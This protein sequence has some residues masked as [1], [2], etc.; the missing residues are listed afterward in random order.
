MKSSQNLWQKMK[1]I[2]TLVK[3]PSIMLG[4]YNDNQKI[5]FHLHTHEVPISS[6]YNFEENILHF[7]N[8]G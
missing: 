2:T 6:P 4:H 3:T 8:Q 5:H 7:P 1:E